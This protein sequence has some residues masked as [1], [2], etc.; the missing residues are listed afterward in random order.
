M[1][2]KGFC[3]SDIC[4][5]LIATNV[6]HKSDFVINFQLQYGQQMKIRLGRVIMDQ[7]ENEY[8]F[9]KNLLLTIGIQNDTVR[10][11]TFDNSLPMRSF[12]GF[13]FDFVQYW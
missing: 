9:V 10:I 8:H 6:K 13:V 7:K 1:K 5:N 11:L 2:A 4:F 12:L 3:R